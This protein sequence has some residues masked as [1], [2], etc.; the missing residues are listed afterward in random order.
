MSKKRRDQLLSIAF[1][2]KDAD[3][4]MFENLSE[5]E[6][7]ELEA[8][9]AVREGLLSL[10]DV[11]ECQLSTERVRSAILGSAVK[12]RPAYGLS[13]ATGT[14]AVL[15]VA[16][17]AFQAG[18]FDQFN[19][20]VASNTT[21]N[22][23]PTI[24]TPIDITSSAPG[25]VYVGVDDPVTTF[26]GDVTAPASEVLTEPARSNSLTANSEYGDYTLNSRRPRDYV[27]LE[28][29]AYF[30]PD[31]FEIEIEYQPPIEEVTGPLVVV[32]SSVE[33]DYGAY[34]ATEVETYGDVVF[35]G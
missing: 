30:P 20:D 34:E 19:P 3:G 8:L 1:G 29:S 32:N 23:L 33:D 28:P 35:G 6:R 25:N 26:Q 4:M 11:P 27:R 14:I 16:L 15:A 18:V 17:I 7:T 9:R 22:P 2:E 31:N 13:F 10:R 5:E 21:D 24:Q 12:K